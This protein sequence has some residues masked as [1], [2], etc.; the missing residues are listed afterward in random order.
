MP[1]GHGRFDRPLGMLLALDIGEILFIDQM[2]F[3]DFGHVNVTR[4][5]GKPARDDTRPLSG[6]RFL[7]SSNAWINDSTAIDPHVKGTI[8][9][10]SSLPA[11]S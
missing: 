7:P 10:V 5:G 6:R 8:H 11:V 4:F 3:K 2:R 9:F 1:A